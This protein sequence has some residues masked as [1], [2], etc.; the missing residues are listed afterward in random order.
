MHRKNRPSAN[1]ATKHGG[2]L[3][4]VARNIP[5][6]EIVSSFQECVVIWLLMSKPIIICCL[7]SA[8][9]NSHYTWWA[10][11]FAQLLTFLRSKQY[12]YGAVRSYIAGDINL[13]CTHWPSMTSKPRQKLNFGAFAYKKF[14][15]NEINEFIAQHPFLAYCLSNVELMLDL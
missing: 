12:E 13:T 9:Q 7:Y 8:P 15:W 1:G 10:A 4:A 14:N 5:S 3:I 11:D 6:C 2:A